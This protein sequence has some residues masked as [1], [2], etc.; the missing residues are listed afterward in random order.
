[1]LRGSLKQGNVFLVAGAF[2]VE[3]FCL[4][5]SLFNVCSCKNQARFCAKGSLATCCG[6]S[7]Q[8]HRFASVWA[9]LVSVSLVSPTESR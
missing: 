2:H 5:E 3:L 1:M 7:L 4:R 8:L 9:L 6:R